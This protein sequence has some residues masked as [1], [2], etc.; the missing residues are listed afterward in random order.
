M[1]AKCTIPFEDMTTRAIL[2]EAAL[3]ATFIT[4]LLPRN[5]HLQKL[6][7]IYWQFMSNMSSVFNSSKT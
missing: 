5:D 3:A 7:A 2:T 4:D 1:I 6:R